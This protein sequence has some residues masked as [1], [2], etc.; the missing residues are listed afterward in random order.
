DTE[1]V[2]T[3]RLES[4]A[5]QE[6][7]ESIPADRT[8][9]RAGDAPTDVF[10]A[11]DPALSTLDTAT[12]AAADA[13]T[14]PAGIRAVPAPDDSATPPEGTPVVPPGRQADGR[15]AD[16]DRPPAA[17]PTDAAPTDAAPTAAAA[18]DAAP[19]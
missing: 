10:P 6:Q 15:S 2:E 5:S 11:V 17:A 14:P 12:F 13:E 3:A 8:V 16:A 7:T 1:T 4:P 19:T 9:D 18:A